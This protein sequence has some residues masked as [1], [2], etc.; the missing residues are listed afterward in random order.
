MQLRLSSTELKVSVSLRAARLMR[1]LPRLQ[2]SSKFCSGGV[3][4]APHANETKCDQS[5]SLELKILPYIKKKGAL[6]LFGERALKQVANRK[7]RSEIRECW[8]IAPALCY[9]LF[10]AIL[11]R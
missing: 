6:S 1:L 8:K 4:T 5:P 2:H 7:K 11:F 3:Y 10:A 9:R